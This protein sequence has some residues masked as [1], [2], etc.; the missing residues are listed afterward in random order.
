MAAQLC[1]YCAIPDNH[2]IYEGMYSD[3]IQEDT[4]LEMTSGEVVLAQVQS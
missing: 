4:Q 1:Q 3:S 2:L